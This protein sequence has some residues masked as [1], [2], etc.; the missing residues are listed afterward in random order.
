MYSRGTLQDFYHIGYIAVQLSC[1]TFAVVW[2][3]V[4]GERFEC[5]LELG[6]R[7]EATGPLRLVLGPNHSSR[8]RR[9]ARWTGRRD[10]PGTRQ[11]G[12]PLS[13]QPELSLVRP[14][15]THA[16]RA[17]S[18]FLQSLLP[19]RIGWLPVHC[20]THRTIGRRFQDR[21]FLLFASPRSRLPFVSRASDAGGVAVCAGPNAAVPVPLRNSS[22]YPRGSHPASAVANLNQ[23]LA[24]GTTV[25]TD[26]VQVL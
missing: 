11:F 3:I 24:G 7:V 22:A 6:I 23:R 12:R 18:R 9:E 14:N 26:D 17:L 4:T 2:L 10:F 1:V 19:V 5:W 8:S 15:A 25:L 13:T 21:S 16:D 20:R